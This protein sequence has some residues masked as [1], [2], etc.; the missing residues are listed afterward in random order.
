MIEYTQIQNTM[1]MLSEEGKQIA[2]SGSH[3]YRVWVALP[4]K[5]A[6]APVGVPELKVSVSVPV[7]SYMCM[8]APF[9]HVY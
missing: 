2:A 3:E 7:P 9:P 4:A 1:Y 5:G 6:G 8:H